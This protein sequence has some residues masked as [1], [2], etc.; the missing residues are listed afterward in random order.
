MGREDRQGTDV[1]NN[2][3]LAKLLSDVQN[4]YGENAVMMAKDMVTYPPV[5]S[6]TLAL[7]FAI[8]VGGLPSDR[9][10]EIGG[11]EGTGKTTLSLLAM[12][13]FLLAQPERFALV[14][15]LE[16]KMTKDWAVQLVGEELWDD[17][18]IY[19]QPDHVEQATNMYSDLVGSGQICFALFDSIGGA[20]VRAGIEKEAEKVQVG[21][22]AN[23]ITKFAR[24]ASNFSAKYRC[25]TVGTNQER[26]DME[27]FRR[28]MTPGG[29]G[30]KHACILRIRLKAS[31]QDKVETVVNGEKMVVGRK[32]HAQI[33]KNQLAAPGRSAWWWMYHVPTE[34]YGFGI[35]TLD[36]IVRLAILTGVIKQRV[37]YY[38]HPALENGTVKGM[39]SLSKAIGDD[40]ALR[41]TI[42][43]ETLAVLKTDSSLLA[44]VAP[45]D[46]T[47]PQDMED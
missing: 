22:N 45:L 44:E 21:G 32:I 23:A 28:Y 5:R 18:V 17:R 29:N 39:T 6:G 47:V 9:V 31:T 11:T 26:V 42:V 41:N 27:G 19:A 24:L 36:E 8:G 37:S 35:D 3:Q 4:K 34:E 38:D 25:L 10:I 33:V 20:A 7:D 46:D 30:W 12:Q 43:S 2:P 1:T 40:E 15:D 16:H 13:Q 14:L